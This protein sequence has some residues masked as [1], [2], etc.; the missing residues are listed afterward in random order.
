MGDEFFCTLL[1]KVRYGPKEHVYKKWCLLPVCNWSNC[2]SLTKGVAGPF[3]NFDCYSACYFPTYKEM[4]ACIKFD[5]I[6]LLTL[7]AS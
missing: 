7:A 5:I 2:F 1:P 4:C 6:F 3:G